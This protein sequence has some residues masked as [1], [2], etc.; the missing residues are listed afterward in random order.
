MNP[1]LTQAAL[2]ELAR[3]LPAGSDTVARL[4]AMKAA[5]GKTQV[6]V[7][8]LLER[9]NALDADVS[10]SPAGRRDKLRE[11]VG[12]TI[13]GDV[14]RLGKVAELTKGKL[15]AWQK[16]IETPA[17]FEKTDAAGATLRAELRSLLRAMS[18]GERI[19]AALNDPQIR[20][21][22]L[23]SLP[24]ASGLLPEAFA[25]LTDAMVAA[26]P[27]RSR[28]AQE[29]EAA[30]DGLVILRESI[31][32]A[33]GAVAELGEFQGHEIGPFIAANVDAAEVERAA[34]RNVDSMAL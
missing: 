15:D 6:I 3:R 2:A 23:E 30:R 18:P 5:T 29:I 10:L 13:A 22:A 4:V 14:A 8:T 28:Q 19:T 1:K 33:R 12:K 27:D 11:F 24:M 34:I 16:R 17:P 31:G 9:K 7:N 20:A 32:L 21:A 25:K 26:D